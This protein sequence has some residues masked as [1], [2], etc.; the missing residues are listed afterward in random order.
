MYTSTNSSSPVRTTTSET[1]P[2]NY[3]T[4]AYHRQYHQSSNNI[5]NN[6]INTMYGSNLSL[7]RGET[8]YLNSASSL[9]SIP[10]HTPILSRKNPNVYYNSPNDPRYHSIGYTSSYR[11][12]GISNETVRPSTSRYDSSG[13]TRAYSY[14]DLLND[15]HRSQSSIYNSRGNV[16]YVQQPRRDQYHNEYDDLVVKST[17]LPATHEQEMIDIVRT[18]FRKYE[19]TNQRELA[20]FLKRAA[21]KTFAPCWHCIVG[22]QFSSYVTHEMNGFI[23]FT[24]GPLSL[25]LFRSGV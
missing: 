9:T 20:G 13:N 24:K 8:G 15:Q 25:L 12:Y 3:Q 18:A 19:I 6:D 7:R 21:D 16:S 17:D 22:R 1:T 5:N 10:S 14:D 11:P 4:Q 23:Y 2:T